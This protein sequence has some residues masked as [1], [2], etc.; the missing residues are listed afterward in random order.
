MAG[1]QGWTL[2]I[3]GVVSGGILTWS[4]YGKRIVNATAFVFIRTA[5]CS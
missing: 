1:I 3:G 4:D 2:E 5:R